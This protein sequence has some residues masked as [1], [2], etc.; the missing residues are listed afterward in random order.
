[1]A[2]DLKEVLLPPESHAT[3]L[4]SPPT[5][6]AADQPGDW[7]GPVFYLAAERG[8]AALFAALRAQRA[9]VSMLFLFAL[10]AVSCVVGWTTPGYLDFP[11]L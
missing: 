1:M 5:A 7:P 6:R 11:V 10:I 3:R 9:L 4:G 8:A 2:S